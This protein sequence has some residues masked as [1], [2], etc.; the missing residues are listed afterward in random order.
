MMDLNEI[1][2]TLQTWLAQYGLRLLG[3]IAVA[4]AGRWV[5]KWLTGLARRGMARANVEQTLINF[6][7]SLT[8]YALLAF[9]VVAAL[10]LIG[11][12]T[13]S[14]VAVFGAATLAVGLALQDSLGNF[15]AGVMIV[16]FRPYKVGDVV[17]IAG[18]FGKVREV[19][20][21]NT[22]LNTLDNKQVIVPN[23]AVMADNITNYT[24][25]GTRRVDMVFGIGY[26]DDLLKAKRILKE[27][28]DAHPAVLA[29]PAPIV[30]VLELGDNSVNFAVRPYTKVDDYWDVYF[31]MHEQVKLRFDEEGI[32][33]PYP[34]RDIHVMQMPAA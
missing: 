28:L 30:S 23:G 11:F 4:V 10:N 19:R 31:Y 25:N 15:A 12:E 27:L 20:I 33:I 13:T 6:A 18:A 21:F 32:S 1:L 29:E 3:A 2:P 7:A 9:V 26:N 24:V 14:I 17:E 34:Q 5:A 16:L 8:Y 22:V